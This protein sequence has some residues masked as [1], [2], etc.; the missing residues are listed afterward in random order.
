MHTRSRR[1]GV[2]L[3]GVI[4]RLVDAFLEPW[5][6]GGS[7]PFSPS[8]PRQAPETEFDRGWGLETRGHAG[9]ILT[10]AR[11]VRQ[12]VKK[13]ER[14]DKGG[15]LSGPG[16]L[17][18][19]WRRTSGVRGPWERGKTPGVATDEF[20]SPSDAKFSVGGKS[21]SRIMTCAIGAFAFGGAERY[22]KVL[23]FS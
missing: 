16:S 12:F 11:Q 1:C 10:Q 19:Q 14:A 6:A 15:F 13:G 4:R 20:V 7:W 23:V 18:G 8:A 2:G 22:V 17:G 9:G 21:L 5:W 3:D